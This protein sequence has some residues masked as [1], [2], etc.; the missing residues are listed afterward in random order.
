MGDGLSEH[1]ICPENAGEDVKRHVL[2]MGGVVG[3]GECAQGLIDAFN[4]LAEKK[5]WEW[6]G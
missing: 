6:N 3:R 2:S 1:A 4:R 5:G